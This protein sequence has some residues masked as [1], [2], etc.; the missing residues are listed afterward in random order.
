[1]EFRAP[2]LYVPRFQMIRAGTLAWI[3]RLLRSAATGI[4]ENGGLGI[5]KGAAYSSLL[6]FFPV[7]TTLAALLVQ[8]NADEVS[9]TV[10]NLLYDVIPPGTEEVVRN[11][12]VVHGSRPKWLLVL[13]TLLATWAASGAVLSL[14]EGFRAAYHIPSGRGF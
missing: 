7:L 11:L 2:S 14:M 6:S 1:M 13:A 12:F 4:Y 3:G 5:A 10:V 8:A 9:R